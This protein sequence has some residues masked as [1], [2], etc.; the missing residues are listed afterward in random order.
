MEFEIPFEDQ[1]CLLESFQRHEDKRIRV[2]HV[3]K[4]SKNL[5]KI[6]IGRANRCEARIVDISVSRLHSEIRYEKDGFWILDSNSK[7]GTLLGSNKPSLLKVNQPQYVQV[8]RSLLIAMVEK[9]W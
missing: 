5:K 4:M 8:G 9:P 1:Y 2:L 6:C 3:L 7:F